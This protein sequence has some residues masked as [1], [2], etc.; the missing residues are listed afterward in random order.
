MTVPRDERALRGR[1]FGG[2]GVSIAMVLTITGQLVG[3]TPPWS[4]VVVAAAT[5]LLIWSVQDAVRAHRALR[6]LGDGR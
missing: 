5:G 6:V 4:L 3:S 1:R 2:I